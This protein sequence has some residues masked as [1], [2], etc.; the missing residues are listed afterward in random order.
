MLIA[1]CDGKQV[2]FLIYSGAIY[3]RNNGLMFA[4]IF[5]RKG[6]SASSISNF[7]N[8]SHPSV[9]ICTIDSSYSLFPLSGFVFLVQVDQ[10]AK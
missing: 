4:L 5:V 10:F 2:V 3:A 9:F 8:L 7:L 6:L 1:V